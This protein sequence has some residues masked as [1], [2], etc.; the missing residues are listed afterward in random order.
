M[1]KGPRQFFA[2]ARAECGR[3]EGATSPTQRARH[4]ALFWFYA[5]EGWWLV[6]SC[7]D[8]AGTQH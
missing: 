5:N 7:P 4:A 2:L 1:T 3:M 8:R 6:N